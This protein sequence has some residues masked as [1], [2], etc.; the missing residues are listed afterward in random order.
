MVDMLQSVLPDSVARSVSKHLCVSMFCA[1]VA[2]LV[3]HTSGRV[4]N[5]ADQGKGKCIISTIFGK[6]LLDKGI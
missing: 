2:T 6:N 5:K 3:Q 1:L 4:L